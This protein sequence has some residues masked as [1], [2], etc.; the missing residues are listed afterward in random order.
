[1][2]PVT[3][4]V[5][6]GAKFSGRVLDPEG[7]PVEGATV[8]PARTGSGNS[9]TGDTRFSVKTD[10]EGRFQSI[11]PA[12]KLFQYNLVAHDGE[13]QQWRKWANGVAVPFKSNPGW[14]IENITI[15]LTRPATVRGRVV[16]EE[17]QQLAGLEVR[18]HAKD[19]LGNRCYDPT[20]K[21]EEDGTFELKYIRPGASYIQVGPFYLNTAGAQAGRTVILELEPGEVVE[22]VELDASE[23]NVSPQPVPM[24]GAKLEFS[25]QLTD[26]QGNPASNFDVVL[27]GFDQRAD[28]SG[29]LLGNKHLLETWD[30]KKVGGIWRTTDE[31]GQLT[32]SGKDIMP[33]VTAPVSVLAIDPA[34]GNGAHG[35]LKPESAATTLKL[36][37]QPLI[38]FKLTLDITEVIAKDPAAAEVAILYGLSRNGHYI[39]QE[40]TTEKQ[41]ILNLPPGRYQVAAMHPS[42]DPVYKDINVLADSDQDTVYNALRIELAPSRLQEMLGKILLQ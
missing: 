10:A 40:S 29:V 24:L 6:P 5:E 16:G 25:I 19:L 28:F 27:S 12:G 34:T 35:T 21:V 4:L 18:A 38:E 8:A 15:Q 22:D 11:M 41:S 3:I 33:N 42:S 36:E 2:E 14:E 37:L 1:M 26:S 31:A 20:T 23:P 30:R 32:V 17:G 9:L 13:Y 39:L 7:S